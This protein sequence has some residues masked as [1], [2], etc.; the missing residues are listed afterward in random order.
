MAKTTK[1]A[2]PKKT[3]TKKAAAPVD[4]PFLENPNIVHALSYFPYFIGAVAMFFLG[5]SD[6]KAAM[7][8]IKYSGLLAV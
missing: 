4:V 3:T 5:R 2:A 7:H 1:K 8:H 6:K